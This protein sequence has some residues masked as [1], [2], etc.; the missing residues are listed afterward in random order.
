MVSPKPFR[1]QLLTSVYSCTVTTYTFS[2]DVRTCN[3]QARLVPVL[4]RCFSET[5]SQ[6]NA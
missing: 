4:L 6:W 1:V 3:M 2:S 5:L